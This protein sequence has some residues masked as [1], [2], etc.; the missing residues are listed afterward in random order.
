[1]NPKDEVEYY[2][3]IADLHR[4]SDQTLKEYEVR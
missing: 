1:M 3:A 4:E 2:Q